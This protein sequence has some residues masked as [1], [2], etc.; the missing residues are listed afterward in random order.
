MTITRPFALLPF[1]AGLLLATGCADTTAAAG[2]G[3]PLRQQHGQHAQHRSV[4]RPGHGASTTPTPVGV[5]ARGAI[6]VVPL[7]LDNAV[8][9]VDL[10]TASVLRRVPLP[11]NSG[12]TG[13]AMV[14]DSIAYV[15]NP[16]LNSVSLV[17]YLTGATSEVPVG[18]YPQGL[19][20]TRG[21]LFV[22][23]GNLVSF[24]PAGASWIGRT[25]DVAGHRYRLDPATGDT[26]FA[27]SA[28]TGCFT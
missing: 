1:A 22:L 23:N 16:G 21:R 27:P 10:R 3:S 12:A 18:V 6:A 28:G 7:G 25:G 14:D 2:G 11:A 9:V 17:N 19:V 4:T 5:S 20:F 13:S 15:G 26:P 24:A 8:A